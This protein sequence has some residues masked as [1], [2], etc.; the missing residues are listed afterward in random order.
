M[1]ST[2]APTSISGVR[3]RAARRRAAETKPQKSA[4][5]AGRAWINGRE[6]A[7]NPRLAHLS[8]SYD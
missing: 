8:L 3:E 7:P 5:T 4:Q 6:I 1:R 2:Q